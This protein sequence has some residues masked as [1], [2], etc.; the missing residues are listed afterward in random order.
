MRLNPQEFKVDEEYR[1]E[2][3]LNHEDDSVVVAITSSS[4]VKG[5]LVDGYASYAEN[6]N[7]EKAKQFQAYPTA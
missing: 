6:M 3:G 2:G 4:G 1:F 7:F 5:T